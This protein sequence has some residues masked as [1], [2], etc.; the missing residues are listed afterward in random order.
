MRLLAKDETKNQKIHKLAKVLVWVLGLFKHETK[1]SVSQAPVS[2]TCNPSYSG[3][4][5]QEDHS[6]R[7]A[8][9][10]SSWDPISRKPITKKDWQSGSRC[11]PC[12][13]ALVPPK[14]KKLWV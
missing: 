13:Q 5:D 14:K 9:T 6:L 2:H 12:V 4:R 7:P 1:M 3:G 8:R 10:N 11:R